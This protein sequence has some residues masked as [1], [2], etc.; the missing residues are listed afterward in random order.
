MKNRSLDP[1]GFLLLL[2]TCPSFEVA[3]RLATEVVSNSLAACVN[4]LN[5]L[6]SVY[7]WQGKIEKEQEHLLLI[8]THRDCY[9]QLELTIKQ[10]HPY[11]VPEIITIPINHGSSEYLEWLKKCLE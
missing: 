10:L 2:C 4:I 9:P 6:L 8:K 1:F 11:E 7:R 5:N 3:D